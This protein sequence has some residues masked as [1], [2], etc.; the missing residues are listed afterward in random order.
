[1]S[2]GSQLTLLPPASQA[3]GEV[4]SLRSA[5]EN[6]KQ[7]LQGQREDEGTLAFVTPNS[8]GLLYL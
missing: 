8:P 7:G 2:E 4:P 3:F 6:T 5:S 1:M